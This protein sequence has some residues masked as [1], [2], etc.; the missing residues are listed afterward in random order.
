MTSDEQ[1]RDIGRRKSLHGEH[2]ASSEPQST[3]GSCSYAYG[4]PWSL[5]QGPLYTRMGP[6]SITVDGSSITEARR[7]DGRPDDSP[8]SDDLAHASLIVPEVGAQLRHRQLA[9]ASLQ[10]LV[11]ANVH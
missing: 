5:E 1:R 4:V 11:P 9:L 8:G 2:C 10:D 3:T 6:G 7:A